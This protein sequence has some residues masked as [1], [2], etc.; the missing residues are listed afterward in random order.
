MSPD[1]P[2]KEEV[3]WKVPVLCE[4][5]V[6][7]LI[8]VRRPKP[9]RIERRWTTVLV[10]AADADAAMDRAKEYADSNAAPDVRWEAFTPMSAS[11]FSLPMALEDFR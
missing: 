3:L 8:G 11:Q 2:T 10:K 1:S 9:S 5:V 6:P 7:A 4:G